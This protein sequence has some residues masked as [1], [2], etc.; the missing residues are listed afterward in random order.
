MKAGIDCGTTLTKFA[1]LDEGR[2]QR[3]STANAK[4]ESVLDE[5]RA[6]GVTYARMTGVGPRPPGGYFAFAEPDGDP[7]ADEIA[8]QADGARRLLGTAAPE[9]F[10]LVSVGTG[11][12]YTFVTAGGNERH[13]LGNAIGG[14]FI[15][16]VSRLLGVIPR[17][18]GSLAEASPSLDILV[19]DVVPAT[20]GSPHGEFVVSHFGKTA[21]G[22]DVLPRACASLLSTV[23]V[24]VVRDVMLFGM[25]RTLPKD[26]VLIGTP[27]TQF[28]PLRDQLRAYLPFAGVM[29][30]F[31]E[32]GE[33]AAAVG[34]LYAD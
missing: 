26:V 6:A 2:L 31:P 18:V 17:E 25:Q 20:A 34:A 30:H 3:F 21:E 22:D 9:E 4:A 29:P 11:V 32:K 15:A 16:G 10:L 8:L 24:S 14:G 7:I 5:M 28:S 1:W 33:Y 27:V 23:A 19:R 13:P 12:S